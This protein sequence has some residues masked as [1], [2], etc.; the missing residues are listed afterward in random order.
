MANKLT[1][2]Q[3][4]LSNGRIYCINQVKVK[5]M[6]LGFYSDYVNIKF[7][8]LVKIMGLLDGN[9]IVTR[10]LTGVLDS[11]EIVIEVLENIHAKDMKKIIAIV[12]KENELE[13]EPE[14]KND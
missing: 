1:D 3:I 9:D 2:T 12:K 13:D 11:E 14:V 6:L 10:F 8:G 7:Y 5:S 4:E